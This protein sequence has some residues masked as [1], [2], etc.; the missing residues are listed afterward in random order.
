MKRDI[1]KNE[2][3][4]KIFVSNVLANVAPDENDIYIISR[5]GDRLD[6]L[7]RRYYNDD[8]KW[9]ILALVNK[10]G[11]GSLSI[12]AGTR[13]RI[14]LDPESVELSIENNQATR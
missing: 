1:I 3:G 5:D 6:T 12:P 14:P 10:L 4:K 2:D 11:K 7:A 9:K 13:I 8:S